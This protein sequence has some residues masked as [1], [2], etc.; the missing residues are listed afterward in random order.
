MAKYMDASGLSHFM[1]KIKAAI[2]ATVTGVKG[3][4]ESSYRTGQVNLTPANIGAVAK[5]GDTMTGNLIVPKIRSA[6]TAYGVTSYIYRTTAL[7]TIVYTHMRFESSAFMPVIHMSG[8]AYGAGKTTELHIAMYM[9]QGEFYSSSTVTNLGAWAPDVYLFTYIEDSIEY[10][11]IG[12]AGNIYFNMMNLDVQDEM[13]NFSRINLDGW[14]ITGYTDTGHIPDIGTN[15]CK[16]IPYGINVLSPPV[17]NA[18]G[19]L[20]IANGGTNATTAAA[21]R[22]NLEIESIT[23]SEIDTMFEERMS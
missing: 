2:A 15:H 17:N 12:L 21:A 4:A 1:A 9:Y 18:T 3:N 10:V 23:N 19:V 22:T 13:G 16:K 7:E 6:K 5:S 11:A 14:T 20:P 8:Y